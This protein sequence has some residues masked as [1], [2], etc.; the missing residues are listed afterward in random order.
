MPS[1][2]PGMNPYLEQADV[3]NDFHQGLI[4][5]IQYAL[6]RQLDPHYIV[7]IEEHLYIHEPPAE[8]R[9][10]LGHADVAL[11]PPHPTGKAPGVAVLGAPAKVELEAFQVERL[12]RVEVRD[13]TG[14]QLITAIELLSPTNKY[15]GADRD[16]YLTKRRQLLASPAHFVEIDL[17]RGG[18]RMPMTGL[19]ECAYCVLV[20]RYEER[21]RA[22]V[23]PIRLRDP[24]PVIPIPV[25][26]PDP[27]ARLDLQDLLHCCYDS[28]GYGTYIY[29]GAPSPNLSA[30]DAA[31]AEQILQGIRPAPPG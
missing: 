11:T 7:K 30:E 4:V 15:A 26:A 28:A 25:R 6:R 24:L 9:R 20:S 8:G 19:P 21:P 12:S 13:R 29:A 23:W 18:P 3:W 2:F 17:L 31:W 14:R 1:P 5:Q 16:Q 22:D 27:D 10:L